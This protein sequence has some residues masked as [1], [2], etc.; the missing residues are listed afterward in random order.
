METG[1]KAPHGAGTLRTAC[2]P[3]GDHCP[4]RKACGALGS[5]LGCANA[6]LFT[7]RKFVSSPA[8]SQSVDTV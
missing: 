1:R 6:V 7:N 4:T 2:Q 8:S 5:H 3:S